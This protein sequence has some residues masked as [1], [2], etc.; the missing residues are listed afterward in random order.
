MYEIILK[1]KHYNIIL[2]SL[3]I[4]SSALIHP[5]V[6]HE[7]LWSIQ[8]HPL[9]FQNQHMH[10]IEQI[11]KEKKLM[12]TEFFYNTTEPRASI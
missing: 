5:K 8:T 6:F 12:V 4:P 9:I 3:Y 1:F 10:V 7:A 2:Y 11:R